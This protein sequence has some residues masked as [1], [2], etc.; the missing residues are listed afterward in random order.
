MVETPVVDRAICEPGS[1]AAG[2]ILI[3]DREATVLVPAEWSA[4]FL[5]DGTTQ[6]DRT[7]VTR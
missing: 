4:L 6:L 2:P 1:G 3:E 7:S 5:E